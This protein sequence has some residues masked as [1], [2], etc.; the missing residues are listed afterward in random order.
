MKQNMPLVSICITCY[1]H[2]KYV[3]QALESAVNQTY[4]NLEILITDDGSTD[5]TRDIILE[6]MNEHPERRIRTFLSETN[7]TFGIVEKMNLAFDGKYMAGFS[8]DDFWGTT[9]VETYVAFMEEHEEYVA[10]FAVPEVVL[11]AEREIPDFFH[12]GNMSRYELFELLFNKGNAICASSMFVRGDVWKELGGWKMQ[13]RQL[14]DYEK[15]LNMLLKY[16]IYFFEK[17]AV[18]VYYRIHENNISAISPE[19]LRRDEVERE[20]ILYHI[21]EEMGKDF[22]VKAF[23][24][25]LVHEVDSESFCLNCE[26]L[27]VLLRAIAAPAES[28]IFF[29]FTH[30]EDTDFAMHIEK[31]YSFF[32]K[33]FLGL[34][35]EIRVVKTEGVNVETL[36]ACQ[37]MIERQKQIIEKLT[38]RLY[39]LERGSNKGL[40]GKDKGVR[41][42]IIVIT[43]SIHSQMIQRSVMP[44]VQIELFLDCENVFA[45]SSE[46]LDLDKQVL[47]EQLTTLAGHMDDIDYVFS[48]IQRDYIKK[49]ELA[50]WVLDELVRI[51]YPAE[52]VIDGW[53]IYRSL[54]PKEK[55]ARILCNPNIKKLD[56]LVLGISHAEAGIRSGFLPGCAVN[57]ASSSQDLYFNYF[58]AQKIWER[59]P[60]KVSELKYVVIDMFDYTYFNFESMLTGATVDFFR[61]SGLDCPEQFNEMGNKNVSQS[62]D[63][64]NAFLKTQW[65][66]SNEYEKAILQEIFGDMISQDEH[67]YCDYPLV[68]RERVVPETMIREYMDCAN[69]TSIQTNI[70]EESIERNTRYLVC[71]LTFLLEKNPEIK[72]FLC[73]LPKYK[74]VEDFEG[75]HFSVWK[76]FFEETL[77]KL[78]DTYPFIYLNYKKDKEISD[79]K[80]YYWDLTHLNYDGSVC[81]TKKLAED[82]NRYVT[83]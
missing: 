38:D 67:A 71:L 34:T 28:A 52:K 69:I 78:Q 1:N 5:R 49:E 64:L 77:A 29:Y 44:E 42:R 26:K 66:N 12:M 9:A 45:K 14:Q 24:K 31:D 19:V 80:E 30:I 83:F 8:G 32:R 3:R 15:W 25:H 36:R 21:M 18:P 16:D 10:S 4:P 39:A 72:I 70:F 22:F 68:D 56:G 57:C 6:I 58:T 7:T 46:E 43:D 60:Q 75:R 76:E 37:D 33:E 48:F 23:G 51:G 50:D 79:H 54:Y 65:P 53:R 20:Y 47:S 17:G 13:Y 35:G 55:Y 59:F 62:A 61:V 82:I 11:E 41:K 73:L 40:T 2:E 27:M 81:F 74:I 63:E